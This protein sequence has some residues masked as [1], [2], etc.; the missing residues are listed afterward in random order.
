[1]TERYRALSRALKQKWVLNDAKRCQENEREGIE[2]TGSS[3][4]E[5]SSGPGK[6]GLRRKLLLYRFLM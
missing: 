6:A 1:M 3:P 5:V 2:R 4:W